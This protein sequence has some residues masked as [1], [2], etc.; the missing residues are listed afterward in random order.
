MVGTVQEI[1]DC[2]QWDVP[3]PEMRRLDHYQN[4][5]GYVAGNEATDP[6][7]T[8]FQNGARTLP[9]TSWPMPAICYFQNGAITLPET[10]W[11]MPAIYYFQNALNTGCCAPLLI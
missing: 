10:S 8:C 6:G 3:F 4:G 2:R 1:F 11:P 7:N 5:T 9:E